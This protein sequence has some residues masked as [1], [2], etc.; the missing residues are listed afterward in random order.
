[1]KLYVALPNDGFI[2]GSFVTYILDVVVNIKVPMYVQQLG[3]TYVQTARDAL[4]TEFLDTDY[5]HLLFIDADMKFRAKHVERLISHDVP[6]VGGFYPKKCQGTIKWVANKLAWDPPVDIRGL[7]PLKHIGTGFMLIRRDV[8]VRM[9]MSGLAASY[10]TD[11][12]SRTYYQFFP[13]GVSDGFMKWEDW[14][15]CE[16][17]HDLGFKVYG[18]TQVTL[19]HFGGVTFPLDTQVHENLAAQN[20]ASPLFAVK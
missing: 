6:V 11:P 16:R 5:T 1:M 9:Q 12:D 19:G 3:D 10:R 8:L 2:P 20:E 13:M 4:A 18:D 15:F 14:S 7:R 17:A